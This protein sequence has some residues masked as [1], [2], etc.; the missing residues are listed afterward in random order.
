MRQNMLT[1]T[2]GGLRLGKG[3]DTPNGGWGIK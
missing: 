3:E 2:V 1:S